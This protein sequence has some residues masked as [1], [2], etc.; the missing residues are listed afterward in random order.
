[1]VNKIE[2]K[3]KRYIEEKKLLSPG[4]TVVV[5]VSGGADSMML[6]YF[7]NR[8][9]AYYHINL[10]VAHIHHGIRQEADEDR[11]YVERIARAWDI[12]CYIHHCD[13]K[14][15]A[16]E[17]KMSEEEVGR[18]ERYNFFISLTNQ[19][20][21]I[22]TAHN[23]NDQAETL[24]MR[25][26]RGT[27]IKGLGG[28]MP[29][30][31]NIIRPILCLTRQE[32]E[33]YCK[34]NSIEYK[35][36]YTNYE[37]IYTRNKVRLECIPYI[38]HKINP[39]IV[40]NLFEHSQIYQEQE[41]FLASYV[42]SIFNQIIQLG[43]QQV[44]VD[45]QRLLKEKIYIQKRILFKCVSILMGHSKDISLKH[46]EQL[47][48]LLHMQNGKKITLP[49]QLVAYKNYEKAIIAYQIKG[50]ISNYEYPLQ[51]GINKIEDLDSIIHLELVGWKTFEQTQ[52]NMYTKYIDYDK[53]KDRLCLRTRQV[54]DYIVLK[55]GSKKLKKF[56][57]DE[58]IPQYLR[59]SYPI[60]AD[61]Q[62]VVWVI[63]SRLNTQY[64]V[65][66]LTKNILEIKVIK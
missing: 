40:E 42:E 15:L 21:K 20:D 6:L 64:F 39:N 26:L 36:D 56:Y 27:D 48:A 51:M 37:T 12:P 23:T 62:E 19:N 10:K 22:A 46:V 52:Q 57:I 58:K 34:I 24:I 28:I 35:N 5:G 18:L 31:S 38:Q 49:N 29:K 41:E 65:T 61:R 63:D 59:D 14:V 17:K 9:K 25:F 60:I 16:K 32:I 8:Y 43:I 30:R 4:D 3:V 11:D 45:I 55:N 53:I 1:M 50:G 66:D 13:V 47:I 54:N 7:L 33:Q 44:E 2:E